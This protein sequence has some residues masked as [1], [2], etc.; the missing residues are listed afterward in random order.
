MLLK[1]TMFSKITKNIQFLFTKASQSLF[2][3]ITCRWS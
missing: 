3:G 1:T 2:E